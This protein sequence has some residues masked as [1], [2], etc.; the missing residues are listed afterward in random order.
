M[1][2]FFLKFG[3][4]KL[5]EI[6]NIGSTR[7]KKTTERVAALDFARFIAIIMMIQGHSLDAL[8]SIN[9]LDINQF[10]WT[11]WHFIRGFTAPVFLIV[12][13]AVQVFANKR[14]NFGVLTK[15]LKKKRMRMAVVLLIIGYMIVFPASRIYD[16]FFIENNI[17]VPFF[18]VGILQLISLSLLMVL[19]VYS[20]TRT[21][22][23][24]GIISLII[25][26]FITIITPFVQEV[27]W[28][29]F[30][31]EYVGAYLSF[32]HGSIFPLFPF[33]AFMFYGLALGALIKSINK[34]KR[35]KFLILFGLISGISLIALGF[36]LVEILSISPYQFLSYEKGNPG[37]ILYRIG[38]VLLALSIATVFYLKLKK[39][40]PFFLIFSK[41]SLAIYVIHLI[42][43]YGTP[44][45]NGLGIVY[46]KYF[47]LTQ[48]TFV[49][50]LIELFSFGVIYM[51]DISISKF[52][53]FKKI[54]RYSFTLFLIF[55]L[56]V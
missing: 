52:P 40:T 37:I 10:P 38:F 16:V 12:S 7:T 56:L 35:N 45:F 53:M 30:L 31:P 47:T 21:D 11:I 2:T 8:T 26:I 54:Y 39:F 23:S 34:E 1:T 19:T 41:R 27:K 13:G 49:T 36:L 22:K 46:F 5:Q 48:S 55:A 42:I 25:A 43:L 29:D 50:I 9:Y 15:E 6:N 44:W 4:Y 3:N 18:Q 32:E 24:L 20:F 33:M 51:Y 28:F 14:N 17:F